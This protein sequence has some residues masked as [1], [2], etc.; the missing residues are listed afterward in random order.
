MGMGI[1]FAASDHDDDDG[2]C[3]DVVCPQ[4][5]AGGRVGEGSGSRNG[6]SSPG[7]WDMMAGW[8]QS[9]WTDDFASKSS[10]SANPYS[11]DSPSAKG[12]RRTRVL[13]AMMWGSE[14]TC[15]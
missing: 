1:A 5:R 13:R 4:D 3:A 15:C 10:K 14:G 6:D 11:D 9:L 8:G 7:S 2:G 12:E